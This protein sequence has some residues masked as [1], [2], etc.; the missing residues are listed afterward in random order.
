MSYCLNGTQKKKN[1]QQQLVGS[2][3]EANR[4]NMVQLVCQNNSLHS[5]RFVWHRPRAVVPLF[6]EPRAAGK[7]VK[8]CKWMAT[9][10]ERLGGENFFSDRAP[11]SFLAS[12]PLALARAP[13]SRAHILPCLKR[14]IRDC[15]QSSLTRRKQTSKRRAIPSPFSS[16]LHCSFARSTDKISS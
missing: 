15:L 11:S 8:L 2:K 14:K 13:V 12:S 4:L 6:S 5:W 10:E 9:K 3:E 7:K 16:Q 1:Q